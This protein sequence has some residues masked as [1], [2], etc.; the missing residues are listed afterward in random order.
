MVNLDIADLLFR[1]L[2]VVGTGQRAPADRR[3]IW[4]KLLKIAQEQN[5]D[6]D[7]ADYR[8]DQAG[9]AWQ[10]QISGPHAKI[11]APVRG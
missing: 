10:A 6:V 1:T 8:F 11:T 9:E 5:I 4:E 2:G 7:Y 3:G